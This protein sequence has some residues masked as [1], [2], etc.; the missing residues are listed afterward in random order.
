MMYL[1]VF[2]GG[3][4]GSLVRFG[5]SNI[6]N[7]PSA[8]FPWGTFA[9]NILASA[10]LAIL[11]YVL[12]ERYQ[13]GNL[14]FLLIVGFCGGFSTFSTLSME[15]F[16]MLKAGQTLWAAGYLLSSLGLSLGLFYLIYQ[17]LA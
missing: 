3:G 4:L 9:A 6:W 5:L 10:L 15:L 7:H 8:T 11:L 14:K 2:L 13:M 1:M 12:P 16:N 17:R